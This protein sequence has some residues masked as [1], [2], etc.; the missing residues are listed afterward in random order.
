MAPTHAGADGVSHSVKQVNIEIAA[1]E[2]ENVITVDSN[3]LSGSIP[4]YTWGCSTALVLEEF[5]W[6]R[7]ICERKTL[8]RLKKEADQAGFK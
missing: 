5:G 4:R 6:F 1:K 3:P 2:E 8:F 7:G